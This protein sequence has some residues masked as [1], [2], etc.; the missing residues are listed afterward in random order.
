MNIFW[1]IVEDRSSDPIRICRYKV[2]VIGVHSPLTS[3]LLTED[4]PWAVPIQNDSAAMSG[5]GK[6]ANGYLQGSTVAVIF[7]DEDLQVPLIL[8]SIAGYPGT[9]DYTESNIS[10]P[11]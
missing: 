10:D 3:E 6:S 7:M 11:V 1:G 5:I 2:R 4:L 9:Q 8:G